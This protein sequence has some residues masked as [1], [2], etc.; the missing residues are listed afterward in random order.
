MPGVSYKLLRNL[1]IPVGKA[2]PI[3]GRESNIAM[4]GGFIVSKINEY[5]ATRQQFDA[6]AA[7]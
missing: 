6:G 5:A 2:D 3:L 7:Q 4:R 1:P